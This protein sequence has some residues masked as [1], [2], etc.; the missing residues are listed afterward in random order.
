MDLRAVYEK[1]GGDYDCVINR[2]HNEERIK[3]YLL[4]FLKY[5]Y[6]EAIQNALN[7]GD[8]ETAFRESHNLKGVCFNLNLD[9]LGDSAEKLTDA[10]RKAPYEGNPFA[11]MEVVRKDYDKTVTA[12]QALKEPTQERQ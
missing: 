4:L 1:F 12:L 11:L 2:L 5:N 6:N 9:A 7:R 10:L 8:Y 3:K